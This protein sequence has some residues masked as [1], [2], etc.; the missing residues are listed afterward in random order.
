MRCVLGDVSTKT[1]VGRLMSMKQEQVALANDRLWML[2]VVPAVA[3]E[4]IR[5][6]ARTER[7]VKK[8][9]AAAA[10]ARSGRSAAGASG[11]GRIVVL[12]FSV[13]RARRIEGQ[14]P[15]QAVAVAMRGRTL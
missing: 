13:S 7:V 9:T 5:R 3:G 8:A 12:F 2:H 4:L 11:G 15:R 10:A 1:G 6:F 14:S